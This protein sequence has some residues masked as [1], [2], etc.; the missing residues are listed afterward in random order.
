[1]LQILNPKTKD[2]EPSDHINAWFNQNLE[3]ALQNK[4]KHGKKRGKK[5]LDPDLTTPPS[6][7]NFF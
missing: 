7:I 3:I 2:L 1:M 5:F 4:E 6:K